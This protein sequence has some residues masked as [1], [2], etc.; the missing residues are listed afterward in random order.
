MGT[1]E[2]GRASEVVVLMRPVT[3]IGVG[4]QGSWRRLLGGSASPIGLG[5]CKPHHN[6]MYINPPCYSPVLPR[7]LIT[8]A[9]ALSPYY[10]S[11]LHRAVAPPAPG[12]PIRTAIESVRCS[13]SE[14]RTSINDRFC[15]ARTTAT[16]DS[17]RKDPGFWTDTARVARTPSTTEGFQVVA[18]DLGCCGRAASLWRYLCIS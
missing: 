5:L 11:V 6:C 10:V 15:P 1:G 12:E 3:F 16:A 18:G 9:P 8:P 2:V 7:V 14:R 13:Q 17:K 4:V